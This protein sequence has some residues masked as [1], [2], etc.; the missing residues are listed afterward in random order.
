MKAFYHPLF[1]T[2]KK[3]IQCHGS[4][5]IF[6]DNVFYWYGENKDNITDNSLSPK[7]KCPYWHHGVKLYSSTDLINWKDEGFAMKESEDI[8]NPFHPANI[9][10]RPHIL[11]NKKTKQFVMWAKSGLSKDF[12][13][14]GYS[15]SA[16]PSL[17]ELKFIKMANLKPHH[18]GDFD[19]FIYKD[20]AYIVYANPH[21]TMVIRELTD[22]YM[23]V[24]DVYSVH[25]RKPY[26][27]YVREAPC[28]FI[29]NNRILML[30][31]GTTAY[32]PNDTICYD[33]TDLHGRWKYVNRP[34]SSDKRHI[35]FNLQ[36]SSVLQ[37]ED[38]YYAI[39]DRWLV[40]FS[41]SA[42]NMDE[43][44]KFVYSKGKEKGYPITEE[45]LAKIS[46]LDVS[47]GEM[48]FIKIRFDN[49]NRPIIELLNE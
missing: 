9:M 44:F 33:I 46:K 22:D 15:I 11:Y 43:V 36:F 32:Y 40:D 41:D 23:D 16:G 39:G 28:V 17:K 19:L 1:D 29:R 48:F 14:C 18:A 3:K 24:N 12:G 26:P 8:N 45:E 2:N 30:T 49:K 31:S 34:C 4:S 35:S 20:K 37:I 27:P 10:D 5:I 13:E 38:E 42:P 25:L 47:K 6:I 7:S 21:T